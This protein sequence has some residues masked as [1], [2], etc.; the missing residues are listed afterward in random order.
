VD[1]VSS[2]AGYGGGPGPRFASFASGEA[3]TSSLRQSGSSFSV[4]YSG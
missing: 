2:A 1:L 4:T 3:T